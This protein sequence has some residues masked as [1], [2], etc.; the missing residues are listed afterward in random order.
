MKHTKI[1]NN[2]KDYND[3]YRMG[4]LS[5]DTDMKKTKI[6]T[7]KQLNDYTRN[8][9]KDM[10]GLLKNIDNELKKYGLELDLGDNSDY[11]SDHYY[12][13]WVRVI[14]RENKL[15]KIQL[16]MIKEKC[17]ACGEG[18]LHEVDGDGEQYLWCNNCDC[19]VDS[20]GGYTN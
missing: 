12:W 19:S 2:L 5:F 13:Y 9:W 16:A 20:D 7:N 18:E 8:D 10:D 17:P 15:S 6:T 11:R 14:E 1:K 3:G 4:Q